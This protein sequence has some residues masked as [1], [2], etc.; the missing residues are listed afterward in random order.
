MT[1]IFKSSKLKEKNYDMGSP[2]I[3]LA[4]FSTETFYP[5]TEWY[6]IFKTLKENIVNKELYTR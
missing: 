4:D 3:S 5:R 1:N 6:D 2:I